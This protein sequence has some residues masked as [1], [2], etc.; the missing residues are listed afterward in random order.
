MSQ[1]HKSPWYKHFWPWYLIFMKVAVI[2]ACI[3]T[4][5]LIYKNP[6]SMVVDDYYNEGRSINLQLTRVAEAEKRDISFY[7]DIDE[8]NVTLRFRSGEPADRTALKVTFYHPTIGDKDFVLRMPHSGEGVY[9]QAL[10]RS[11]SGHW[12]VDIEPFD[13]VWRVS[14]NIFLPSSETITLRPVN[15]GI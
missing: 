15:Y 12:R 3:V 10:P 11:I 13:E 8:Q 9:R 5:I 4:A 2:T 14:Q 6:T 7:A 1:I